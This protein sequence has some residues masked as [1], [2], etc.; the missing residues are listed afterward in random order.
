MFVNISGAVNHIKHFFRFFRSSHK[1]PEGVTTPSLVQAW[2]CISLVGPEISTDPATCVLAVD[3]AR[4]LG[5]PHTSKME[6]GTANRVRGR[7]SGPGLRGS[8]RL[9]GD[10]TGRD[11]MN[12]DRARILMAVVSCTAH[13]DSGLYSDI[14]C[15][16]LSDWSNW[17]DNCWTRHVRRSSDCADWSVWGTTKW[18]KWWKWW[19]P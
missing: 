6:W 1:A 17:G 10:L 12:I 19:R 16:R 14:T 15:D 8:G 11:R 13:P 4:P 2:G 9:L 3:M 5:P 18:W 7:S